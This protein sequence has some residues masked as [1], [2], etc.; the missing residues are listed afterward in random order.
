MVGFKPTT[1]AWR[2]KNWPL[3][4]Y[5]AHTWAQ[6]AKAIGE[7][8]DKAL[9]Q[10]IRD[11]FATSGLPRGGNFGAWVQVLLPSSLL[12][13]IESTQPLYHASSFGFTSVVRTLLGTDKDLDIEAR[14]GRRGSSALQVAS[15]QGHVDVVELLLAAHADPRSQNQ[16]GET[17]LYWARKRGFQEIV[18]LLL[19]FGATY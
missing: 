6:H 13:N 7:D 18:D 17:S 8:L 5:A 19:R 9:Q 1:I 3:L 11:F 16:L 4:E 12:E 2:R 14:G 10:L 15:F